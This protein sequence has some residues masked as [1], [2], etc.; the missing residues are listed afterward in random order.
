[1]LLNDVIVGET[2]P[3]DV[4]MK[5][6]TSPPK[7]Y[8]SVGIYLYLSR[9][10]SDGPRQVCGLPGS[11]LRFDETCVYN[12]DAIRPIYLVLYDAKTPVEV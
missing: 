7:G 6:A 2:F 4:A 12:D 9:K 8:D 10:V 5:G 11:Q 3:T 1:M